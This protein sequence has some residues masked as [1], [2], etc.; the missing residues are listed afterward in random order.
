MHLAGLGDEGLDG[1]NV[2]ERLHPE[3]A[4]EPPAQFIEDLVLLLR[5]VPHVPLVHVANGRVRADLA[6]S[7]RT[8]GVVGRGGRLLVYN[9]GEQFLVDVA[10][11]KIGLEPG[12]RVL[13]GEIVIQAVL[14]LDLVVFVVAGPEDDGRMMAHASYVRDRFFLHRV[15]EG[16]EGWII[17][18]G[19]HEVLPDHDA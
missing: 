8:A 12:L 9:A 13:V 15:E 11:R 4:V 19:K 14:L 10:S 1:L 16:F 2:W 5:A 3:L 7:P 18:A 17:A 6:V